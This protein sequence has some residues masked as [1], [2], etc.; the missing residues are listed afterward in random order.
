MK[1]IGL[2][3][4]SAP[5]AGGAFQY[6]QSMLA[7]LAALPDDYQ[8]VAVY[9]HPAWEQKLALYG[10]RLLVVPVHEGIAERIARFLLKEGLPVGAW[11]AV[12]RV[13]QPLARRL[14]RMQ[15]ALWVFPAQDV[16]SYALAAPTVGVIHDLMHLYETRFPEVGD[17]P[18]HRRRQRHYRNLC[19]H[20]T[21]V[22]V[23]S[24]VGRQHVEQAFPFAAGRV[25]PLPY[26]APDY[27]HRGKI[28]DGFDTRYD[29]PGDF[30][31][32]PAQFW[33]HKN[34]ERLID[35]L[36]IVREQA[37]NMHLVLAGSEKNAQAMVRD[38]IEQLGLQSFVHIVGHVPDEDMPGFY[39]RARALVMPT[40]FGPTNI[41]PLEAMAVG[42]PMALSRIY[43]MPAQVG[44][45]AL[46]FDPSSTE[47]IA[48]QL[49]R[50]A[51]DDALC[52]RLSE[53]GLDRSG[54]WGPT[55]FNHALRRIIDSALE[56]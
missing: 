56:H 25:H 15:C 31:F 29:L 34:H 55:E 10:G 39:R 47:D 22:L 53:A 49:L 16:L 6:S 18:L 42:C 13:A 21:A 9:S 44:D 35:A 7:A 19:T 8:L 33:L 4:S 12:A 30:F 54:A 11:H 48:A 14:L 37:P 20:A 36:A 46:W 32:Y 5:E 40:F 27:I 43:G 41:P 51:T 2:Y 50:M 17:K 3:L 38:R 26:I 28:P 24:E 52:K 23:D 45:A 1:R